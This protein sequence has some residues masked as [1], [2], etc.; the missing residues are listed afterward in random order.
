MPNKRRPLVR[1]LLNPA[2]NGQLTR[3]EVQD[4]LG[5]SKPTAL[6]QVE[7]MDTLGI[8]EFTEVEN[9]G[10]GTKKLE[11]KDEFEWPSVLPFPTDREN[12]RGCSGVVWN[13]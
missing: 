12:W 1:A 7:L 8:A 2:N 5:V 3:N 11:L 10:R 6:D 9:D 4:A 13:E